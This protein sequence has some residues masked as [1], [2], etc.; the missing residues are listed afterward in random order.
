M[1]NSFRM[2]PNGYPLESNSKLPGRSPLRLLQSNTKEGALLDGS[3]L[4]SFATKFD[5]LCDHVRKEGIPEMNLIQVESVMRSIRTFYR[6]IRSIFEYSDILSKSTREE[7]NPLILISFTE[8]IVDMMNKRVW[9]RSAE[10]PLFSAILQKES[11]TSSIELLRYL[12]G[13]INQMESVLDGFIS[14]EDPSSVFDGTE[15]MKLMGKEWKIDQKNELRCDCVYEL[16]MDEILDQGDPLHVLEMALDT[17]NLVPLMNIGKLHAKA[18]LIHHPATFFKDV[19]E[20]FSVKSSKLTDVSM[21]RILFFFTVFYNLPFTRFDDVDG[22]RREFSDIKSSFLGKAIRKIGSTGESMFKSWISSGED[23]LE[24][25]VQEDVNT[26]SRIVRIPQM[27]ISTAMMSELAQNMITELINTQKSFKIKSQ[28]QRNLFE[29]LQDLL[30]VIVQSTPEVVVSDQTE[31]TT[32]EAE[33][34]LQEIR[35]TF[36]NAFVTKHFKQI[37]P[38]LKKI[39]EITNNAELNKFLTETP[40]PTEGT[41]SLRDS[42]EILADVRNLMDELF[43]FS[44]NLVYAALQISLLTRTVSD[45]TIVTKG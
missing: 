38:F 20:S 42:Q 39:R 35:V 14:N 16:H 21:N 36:P 37:E 26:M 13:V 43:P 10:N 12:I 9:R 32:E 34:L 3:F 41:S 1:V 18:V 29:H 30:S 27:A 33:P 24:T 28:T 8:S 11:S 44:P 31:I 4:N 22:M 17:M 6:L 40:R 25:D 5:A 19:F 23:D 2:D 15:L 45:G 7:K